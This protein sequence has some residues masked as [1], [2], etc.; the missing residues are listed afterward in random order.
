MDTN[1]ETNLEIG[2][3]ALTEMDASAQQTDRAAMYDNLP[4]VEI[5]S[6]RDANIKHFY[7]GNNRYQ[8]ITYDV[9]VHYRESDES[10][11]R[12]IDNTL[13]EA[14]DADAR[15]V[16]RNRANSLGAEFAAAAD[17]GPLVRLTH[18]G[19]ALTWKFEGEPTGAEASVAA[20]AQ[21]ARAAGKS[22]QAS[23]MELADRRSEV[24]YDGL[25]PGLSAKY[26]L[27]GNRVKEDII[28]ADADA[29]S[30]AALA[31][32][33]EF[34][35]R[36][37]PNQSVSVL[38]KDSGEELFKF[39]SPCA[40]DSSLEGGGA[41]PVDV[42]L[43]PMDGY[44]RMRYLPD[45]E[46]LSRAV[47]PITIDP[48]VYTVNASIGVAD[49]VLREQYPNRAFG[50]SYL[51]M[52]GIINDK[53][54]YSLIRF[55]EL[56]KIKASDTI[57]YAGL[58]VAPNTLQA[59]STKY[60]GAYA[61]KQTFVEDDATYDTFSPTSA[62]N[63]EAEAQD[64]I[65]RTDATYVFF[66]LTN[67]YR[68]WYTLDE[69][70]ATQNFGVMLRKP[71]GFPSNQYYQEFYTKGSSNDNGPRMVVN[72]VS[73]AGLENWWQYESRS[74]G[75]A[76]AA[77]VDI[78]NGNMVFEHP[79]TS[80]NGSRMPVSVAHYY[81]SCQCGEEMWHCG[82]GWR[83]SVQQQ[84]NMVKL[85]GDSGLTTYYIWTDGDGIEHAFPKTGTAPYEDSEGMGL[86]LALP[87]STSVT[88]TDKSHNVMTFTKVTSKPGKL[89]GDHNPTFN[90][91]AIA[92]PLGNTAQFKYEEDNNST[93]TYAYNTPIHHIL[94]G[95]GR[96]TAFTYNSSGL[97]E[98]VSAPGNPA[99]QYF[100]D[101]N[102]RLAGISYADLS[103][104]PNTIFTYREVD[105]VAG[106][107][108]VSAQNYA[109]ETVS[110]E[111]VERSDIN[112]AL[113]SEGTSDDMCR[114]KS[115]SLDN[116]AAKG[117]RQTF[118]YGYM[119][120]KITSV[121]ESALYPDQSLTYQFNDGGNVVAVHDELGFGQ[122]NKFDST[123]ANHPTQSS[124]LQKVVVN[125]IRCV[126][127]SSYA[128]SISTVPADVAKLWKYTKA[129]ADT[130]ARDSNNPC[131]GVAGMK[132]QRAAGS[133]EA[134][135]S[136]TMSLEG[137]GKW[138]F[139]AYAKI[140]TALTGGEAFLRVYIDA[141][142]TARE[143]DKLS[144]P[145]TGSGG[146]ALEDWQRLH[147]VFEL[148][149][150]GET[151]HTV[152]VEMVNASSG[153]TAWFG[154]P[155]VEKGVVPN[156][157]NLLAN[158]DMRDPDQTGT[159]AGDWLANVGISDYSDAENCRCDI[160]PDTANPPAPAVFGDKCLQMVSFPKRSAD[161]YYQDFYIRGELGDVF[162]VGGWANGHSAPLPKLYSDF[163]V[164]VQF[165]KYDTPAQW[166]DM[167]DCPFNCEWV[168][169]Q[170]GSFAVK[171]PFAYKM[172]R[173]SVSYSN[174]ANIAQF[175]N[176]F[177]HKEQFGSSF[178]YDANKNVLS[179]STLAGQKS[180]V[181]YDAYDNLISYVQP[182]RNTTNDKYVMTYG[183][184]A[185]QQKEH[186][187]FTV[188]TPENVKSIY[189]YDPYGNRLTSTTQN[190]AGTLLI[191]ADTTYIA[192]GNYPASSADARGNTATQAIDA[193]TG[194]LSSVTDPAGQSV[195]YTYDARRRVTGVSATVGSDTYRNAYTY[196]DDRLKTVGHNTTSDACD[197]YYKFEYD[198][199]GRQT[200]VKVG[201][202]AN[203]AD[204]QVLSTNSYSDDRDG[205]LTGVVYENTYTEEDVVYNQRVG[206]TYDKDNRLT[207]ISYDGDTTPRYT[208]E[209]GANGAAA[210]VHDHNLNRKRMV[211]YD[212][213]NRPMQSTLRDTATGEVLYKTTLQYDAFSNLAAF[214]E[215]VG[216]AGY[217]TAYTYDTENRPTLVKYMDDANKS[218]AYVYDTVGRVSTRTVKNTSGS[219]ATSTYT[220]VPGRSGVTGST[221][222]L[223][224]SISQPGISFAYEYDSRGN[225]TKETRTPQG[226]TAQEIT[227]AY[228]NLNQLIRVNDP[229]DPTADPID[230]NIPGD[231]TD[232]TTWVYAYDLGGNIT[233]K[234]WYAYT[235]GTLPENAQGIVAYSYGN[236]NWKDQLTSYAGKVIKYDAIGNPTYSG[237]TLD[238]N[239]DVISYEWAYQWRAGRQL[240]KM[241]DGS[242]GEA[243]EFKYNENGLRTQKVK[244]NS[245]GTVLETTDYTLNGKLVTHLK[246]GEDNLHFFYDAQGRPAIVRFNGVDYHYVN[247]LQ[248]DVVGMVDSTGTLAVEYRYK[249][250]G[251]PILDVQGNVAAGSMKD[252]LGALNPFR[253]RGYVYDGETVLYY[254]RSRY[255]NPKQNGFLNVDIEIGERGELFAHNRYTYCKNDPIHRVD[256][257]G[258]GSIIRPAPL[259]EDIDLAESLLAQN[260]KLV[261]GVA[262]VIIAHEGDRLSFETQKWGSVTGL[263]GIQRSCLTVQSY[264]YE[265]ETVEGKSIG[266]Y[267][268]DGLSVVDQ[269]ANVGG[270]TFSFV[271]YG[272][273]GGLDIA[274]I[275]QNWAAPISFFNAQVTALTMELLPPSTKPSTK[276]WALRGEGKPEHRVFPNHGEKWD[277]EY[278]VLLF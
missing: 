103:G 201:E 124:K 165:S 126:D 171:A 125:R 228:D 184:T 149:G 161:A 225:I 63:V 158:A 224:A 3:E 53:N 265:Q 262:I 119:A 80:M 213:A 94:D 189:T 38:D 211:E 55:E 143:S 195:A 269:A 153:G 218:V 98:S 132:I 222:P 36:L 122:F 230:P 227:Y 272:A 11:W 134:V 71:D 87:N 150:T 8:A 223:V 208:Y 233:S 276:R 231:V 179:A 90:I 215:K 123:I 204:G 137:G 4:G 7:L 51:M 259:V 193:I 109:G 44:V 50:T 277:T 100:Y 190:S 268:R 248:G 54:N 232:G 152:K 127:M 257:S 199:L 209:Y 97:L 29:L 267:V 180:D 237:A 144:A 187:L 6:R 155:Q 252:T 236:A 154:L 118:E 221:T 121:R 64:F 33:D 62:S 244:K 246:K 59:S 106:N 173:F 147:V 198:E 14:Q 114:V 25:L 249:A 17:R 197:V 181:K 182:G 45:A 5:V 258:R 264:T 1:Q 270:S 108:L 22:H 168:G 13:D 220:Y 74:A 255:Y 70:G 185:A 35:Y 120:T 15:A 67:L 166:G 229:T 250:W 37:H 24:Y 130:V 91:T 68:K 31:L 214:K 141:D 239:G 241:T 89:E 2:T 247:N 275:L 148:D 278:V 243:Y 177:L 30:G 116:G 235:T 159:F 20:F 206:S 12:E 32:P 78:F 105:G 160:S 96:E 164:M 65:R 175:S 151:T 167:I 196:D 42:A 34:E 28:V 234:S 178:A 39:A 23:R 56:V 81:N 49:T 128:P 194:T 203:P 21:M 253:Y 19:K 101:A 82:K 133:G 27:V 254:L 242:N 271:I 131:M 172:V 261:E 43:T 57:L 145:T 115:L 219:T 207:G 170:F 66:D 191:K 200:S 157:V 102:G 69:N 60:V 156:R 40:F 52:T 186:Q 86:K 146:L 263:G 113:L 95:A 110:L 273:S 202:T 76:G 93:A 47:Y 58:R 245:E 9:P 260:G 117:A 212:L 256:L 112:T 135:I 188:T 46:F 238:A 99:L 85:T 104:G 210:E 163:G 251:E 88:I 183:S 169:W 41:A 138:S 107:L 174:N 26:T 92:D 72:Y 266:D 16:F 111:Y 75:R 226:G 139:S 274:P 84:V 79:D 73:H 83:M 136:Q 140:A 61:L 162:A 142:T 10:E 176:M 48:I 240:D 217:Q 77:H 129:T 216:D 205:L 192:N 18:R